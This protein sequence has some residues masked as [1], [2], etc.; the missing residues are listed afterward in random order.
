MTNIYFLLS[1][2]SGVA[3]IAGVMLA[4]T[5]P[6]TAEDDGAR[7]IGDLQRRFRAL[8]NL[9]AKF[10]KRHYWKLVDQEQQIAGKLFVEKPNRFRLETSIQTVVTDGKT[11][12]N[13]VPQN[14]QVVV[15]NYESVKADRSY[16]KLLFDL[17]LL[18]GYDDRFRPEYVGEERVEGQR[19]HR[20]DLKS[21]EEDGYITDVRLWMDRRDGLVR[22]VEYHNINNDV[23]TYVLSDFRVNRK[24]KEGT[25]TF[26]A[27]DETDVVDLR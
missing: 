25:F 9:E 5:A 7:V 24:L 8:E 4:M 10:E 14:Q 12:W 11:A 27:G 19:T 23:T 26:L 15:S 20:V 21:I 3:V 18:G 1:R 17:V 6:V 22:K 2:V 13:Y 16:E